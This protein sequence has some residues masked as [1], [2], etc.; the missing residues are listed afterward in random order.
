MIETS[1]AKT[2]TRKY[3]R[4]GWL[5]T[6]RST[7]AA[8]LLVLPVLVG[9]AVPARAAGL[10][11]ADGGFG[12]VLEIVDHDVRVTVDNGIAVTKVTQVFRNKERR[13]LEALYTFPV[14]K[15]ASVSDFSMWIN[16]K[17]MVGEVVEKERARQIYESYK[18]TKRDPGLLEQVDYKTFEMR[19]FPIGPE[20]EQRLQ[21][22]YYQELEVD[23]DWCTYVYPLATATRAGADARTAGRFGLNVEVRSAVPIAAMESPSHER[24]MIVARHAD[25]F[26]QAS[27][28]RTAGTNL[29]RDIVVAFRLSRPQT[30][31]DLVVH[32]GSDEEG[33]FSLILTPGEETA[34]LEEGMDYVFI[35]D[36]S[37]SMSSDG[38]LLV[39]KDSVLAFLR[40]L[41]AKDRFEVIAFNVQPVVLFSRLEPAGPETVGR[42]GTFV[43]GQQARGGTVLNLALN[44]AYKYH[45]ADR[46]LNVVLLSDGMTEQ[47]ERAAI[48]E[49]IRKRPGN[50]R[51]FCIGV[52]N[53]VNRP[54]LE[55]LAQDSGGLA[56][57]ISRGDNFE[58]QAKAF[59]RKLQH[60]VAT[61]LA[62]EFRGVEVSD[63]EPPVLPNLYHGSPVRVYGRYRGGGTAKVTLTGEIRG[64]RI[65]KT[66][67]LAFPARE[68]GNPEIERMWAWHRIDRLLKEADR[69]G[70]R[71][72]AVAEVVRLGEAFSIASEH[73]SF[74]VLEN[75]DEY[76]RWKIERRNLLLSARDRKQH[77]RL[78]ASL[79]KIRQKAV[80]DLGPE[81][82]KPQP[83]PTA[84]PGN[85]S[86]PART[87]PALPAAPASQ[88]PPASSSR[89]RGF[90]INVGSGPVGPIFLAAA[91]WLNRRRRKKA[92]G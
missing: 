67:E 22:T 83:P 69:Q 13:Q 60:P 2:N 44:V 19:V 34:A 72:E 68:A 77:E 3:L 78:Q 45:D 55:Q 87:Q 71:R 90:D 5:R 7:I 18:Q 28:E 9:G 23:Q 30:G 75:D 57:F 31:I 39:S 61:G 81:A 33:S 1:Q 12:G 6:L 89:S 24:E 40:E 32:R 63:L 48:L 47:G 82:A 85:T 4:A 20:A 25:N 73:T 86:A 27:L 10:L 70:S 84:A 56:A 14:P 11:I 37:G 65:A 42:A 76:R 17:E 49:Q 80:A 58:R 38:K 21:I 59:R 52:G 29:D 35:M 43:D 15:G 79:D 46:T 51:V 36:V 92:N 50:T 26:W 16:G 54:L 8:L 62:L 91:A 66:A 74:I 88:P 41:D 53:E 64:K